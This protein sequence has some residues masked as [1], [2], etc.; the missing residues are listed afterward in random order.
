MPLLRRPFK[1]KEETLKTRLP[2]G[3]ARHY[4]MYVQAMTKLKKRNQISINKE[5]QAL[6]SMRANDDLVNALTFYLA[7]PHLTEAQRVRLRATLAVL[8]HAPLNKKLLASL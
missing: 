1:T 5:L 8:S 4:Y 7:Q 2:L 3:L 6:N